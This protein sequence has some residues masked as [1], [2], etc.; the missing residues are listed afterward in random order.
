M[1]TALDPTFNPWKAIQ[2]F[3]QDMNEQRERASRPVQDV[4][5][6]GIRLLR[7][8]I[9]LP[10]QSEAFFSKALNG[11]LEI[12]AQLSTKSTEDLKR[13]E[14]SV[15]RLTWAVVFAALLIC[16]TVLMVNASSLLGGLCLL[17]ALPAFGRLV[18][19]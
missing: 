9:Q 6:E 10:N 1:L 14:A 15:S 2:P 8:T 16:G 18:L 4:I 7:Q 13:I 19:S 17:L 5:N 12:R 11:Q 3:A